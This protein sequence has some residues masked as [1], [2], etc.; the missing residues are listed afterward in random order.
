MTKPQLREMIELADVNNDGGID[1]NEFCRLLGVRRLSAM[2][3]SQSDSQP[4]QNSKKR[5]PQSARRRRYP[6][7]HHMKEEEKNITSLSSSPADV[8]LPSPTVS[9][10]IPPPPPPHHLPHATLS[11]PS[12]KK[13][14]ET[15]LV[16]LL[17]RQ[18][19]E[20]TM[21]LRTL[22]N[23]VTEDLESSQYEVLDNILT[24]AERDCKEMQDGT[25]VLRSLTH[26]ATL[27]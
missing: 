7:Q 18:H 22:R 15:R 17:I 9:S 2:L 21:L 23:I 24:T 27:Y 14:M 1:Y 20:N 10:P 4:T 3:E 8:E 11:V 13:Y 12:S 5:S 19:F 6:R 25:W 16:N 26:L